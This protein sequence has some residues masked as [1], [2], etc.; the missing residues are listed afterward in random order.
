MSETEDRLSE[1]FYQWEL[2]GRGWQLSDEP[3]H[4]E[5]AFTPFQGHALAHRTRHDDGKRSTLLSSLIKKLSG[6]SEI[7]ETASIPTETDEDPPQTLERG[8][9]QEIK[10]SLPPE[11][12]VNKSVCENFLNSLRYCREPIAFE[13]IATSEG[14]SAQW[15]ACETDTPVLQQ[16]LESHFSEAVH[17]PQDESSL[18]HAWFNSEAEDAAI[19]EFGLEH[20][21]MTPLTC[22]RSFDPDPFT[23][24]IAALSQL[25]ENETA[26]Y[27]I[28]FQPARAPWAQSI[29]QSVSDH[30]GKNL[31]VNRPE[32]ASDAK[33]KAAKPLFGVVLRIA[34]KSDQRLFRLA[35]DI[36]GALSIFS[37]P[38]S[39]ELIPLDN[40][41]YNASQHELDLLLR[42]SC[43]SGMLLNAD[44]LVSLAHP[45]SAS[46][47][48]DRFQRE[49]EK[50]HPAPESSNKKPSLLL[51]TNNHAGVQRE[52]A[53]T[54]EERVRHTHL[55][56]ASGTGKSTLLLNMIRQDMENGQGI[57]VFDPHGD[58]IDQILGFV[59][60]DRIDD[61]IL[62][63]PSDED[64]VVGFN[65]LSAKSDLEKTLLASDLVSVFQRLS[66]SW[67]DQMTSV[68]NNAILAFLESQNGGTLI[69]LQRF[70]IEPAFREQFLTTVSDEQV[71]YYWDQIFTQLSGNKSVGPII[72]RLGS[73]LDR[74]PIRRMVTQKNSRFDF[75]DIMDSGKIFLARLPQG[76]IGN[77]NAYLLGSFLVSKFQQTVMARQ[78]KE[79][80]AR[81]DFWMYLDEFHNFI[82]PSMAQILTG[83]RKYR[84]GLTLA[85]QELRQLQRESEVASAALSN[86]YTRICFRVGD[87][88]ARKIGSGFTHFDAADIQ[89]LPNFHAIC[90]IERADCDFNLTLP[91]PPAVNRSRQLETADRAT[92]ASRKQY[93]IEL[94]DPK[95]EPAPQ[96]QASVGTESVNKA[97][98]SVNQKPE[99]TDRIV[100][101]EPGKG[102]EQHRA[103]QQRIKTEAEALGFSISI[104]QNITGSNESIDAVVESEDLTVACEICVTTSI[105]H[106]LGN[107]RKCLRSGHSNIF[108]ICLDAARCQQLQESVQQCLTQD[109]QA[110]IQ[111]IRPDEFKTSLSELIAQLEHP[112]TGT[113]KSAVFGKYRVRSKYANLDEEERLKKESILRQIITDAL[114]SK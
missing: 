92:T 13:F 11:Y 85:H 67:G 109:E 46:I 9:L 75:A 40:A 87:D 14:V 4:P 79:A 96:D 41:A 73:F 10:L 76:Q 56:G 64:H 8:E 80:D 58:L 19:F 22:A 38:G 94:D 99:Q 81:R 6:G 86:P 107:I 50:T 42:Q 103:I 5:P 91:S 95:T 104:E 98:T 101:E 18:E 78:A 7:S 66:T 112:T 43:R 24:L 25:R 34:I 90:R 82:T 54:P 69:D 106:E 21:F 57:A 97:V 65:I 55:I 62:I 88:D 20:E 23:A 44:E 89:K 60:D 63:D 49:V 105:D 17:I 16:Q 48:I 26:I 52:V 100:N 47:R 33:S 27:Q 61:V 71:L 12:L 15:V 36:A 114:K 102:G 74:K 32:L 35:H 45:P 1:N 93:G 113:T 77:E 68:L 30:D 51:G 111:C 84:L 110:G 70:L 28:V 53:I 83:A 2:R 37:Q 59:P 29:H 3:V 31:F 72:T 108:A 39:N